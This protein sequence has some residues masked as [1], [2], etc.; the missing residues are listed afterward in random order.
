MIAIAV[1][2]D[3]DLRPAAARLDAGPARADYVLAA[4]ALGVKRGRIV[5]GHVL[6]NSL[7]PVIVQ[8]TLALATAIIDAAGAVL[9]RPGL[10][11]PG[12]P[13][14][15]RMLADAQPYL[16]I[17]PAAG[18]LPGARH[19]RRRARVHP[20]GR[21]AARGPRP[22]VPAV[23]MPI[24]RSS[25]SCSS[26]RRPCCGRDFR[27]FRGAASSRPAPSTASASTS[28]PARPSAWSASPAAASRSPRWPSWACCPTAAPG[29][30]RGRFDGH[31]L[32]GLPRPRTLR[33]CRGRDIA[34][35]FQDPLSSLNPVVPIGIQVTEVLERHRGH[36]AARRP[37]EAR[38]LLD[39]VGIPDPEPAAEGVPA[40]AV[41]RH[42]PARADR[43]GAGLQAPAAHRRRADHRAGRDDPGADPRAAQ[44]AGQRAP[45]PRW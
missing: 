11:R 2:N 13:E 29:R 10:R 33:R 23:T 4:T 26:V 21:V 32:L 37:A 9:P 31:E 28:R 38:D 7:A 14:W 3:P 34:M 15:G 16:S 19:H 18:R 12:V 24:D 41:R 44:G 39:R 22:E 35:I 25:R 1:V 42:A 43:D 8:A 17:A 20:A 45:A 36:V 30:G 6:P 27:A 5:F 40:P